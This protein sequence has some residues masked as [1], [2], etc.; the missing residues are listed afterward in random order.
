MDH[1][2]EQG[3]QQNLTLSKFLIMPSHKSHTFAPIFSETA[4]KP[5]ASFPAPHWRE[6][7][8]LRGEP[9]MEVLI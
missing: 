4:V 6:D 7:L 2:L 9:G 3:P 8:A 1:H 5:R